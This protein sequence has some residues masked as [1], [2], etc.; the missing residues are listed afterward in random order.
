M[1]RYRAIP[2]V[3]TTH[4]PYAFQRHAEAVKQNIDSMAGVIDPR[5]RVV[6]IADL[7]SVGAI[8]PQQASALE[9]LDG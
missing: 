1:K 9:K 2:S 5:S 7:L 4:E 8:S 6:T 3:A